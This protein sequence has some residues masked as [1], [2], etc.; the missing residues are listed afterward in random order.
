MAR[1]K[2]DRIEHFGDRLDWI[3]RNLVP[4]G[5]VKHP[6]AIQG[7][8]D[9]RGAV[10]GYLDATSPHNN[11]MDKAWLRWRKEGGASEAVLAAIREIYPGVKTEG[12]DLLTCD[13]SLFE[14]ATSAAERA[15]TRWVD[16]TKL[17]SGERAR[18]ERFGKKVYQQI[19]ELRGDLPL[20]GLRS[21]IPANAVPLYRGARN[22][23]FR[24]TADHGE[25][26]CRSIALPGLLPPYHLL[27]VAALGRQKSPP[28]NGEC[29]L[30]SDV[31]RD[32]HRIEIKLRRGLYFD[33]LDTCEA[34]AALLSDLVV[35]GTSPESNDVDLALADVEWTRDSIL[36]WKSRT[37]FAGVNCL[38]ITKNY[39]PSDPGKGEALFWL[40]RRG[41]QTI[42]AQGVWHVAPAGGHQPLSK[43]HANPDEMSIWYTAVRELLEEI[44]GRRELAQHEQKPIDHFQ[45][46]DETR[47]VFR[48][49]VESGAAQF[50]YLGVG[51]DPATTK[52][53]MLCAIVLDWAIAEKTFYAN[54]TEHLHKYMG[55]N[56]EGDLQPYALSPSLMRAMA[57]APRPYETMLPAGAACLLLAAGHIESGSIVV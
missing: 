25:E 12:A 30:I 16:A 46:D 38:L 15:R 44:F 24:W 18:V 1:P 52:P 33:Y 45:A 26:G 48:A 3:R 20:V 14:A 28:F 40:H 7:D 29:Y 4:S 13:W 11:F 41:K 21:W 57:S 2:R 32:D 36:D 56:W 42:E 22:D 17:F 31:G 27:K 49:V 8:R 37:S 34:H 50:Y 39:H 23:Q 47:A 9:F 5:P 19:D 55:A 51:L 35:R 54:R 53:E 43:G 10:Q 6:A